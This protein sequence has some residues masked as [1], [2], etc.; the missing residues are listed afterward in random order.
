MSG[1]TF[2]FDYSAIDS[3]CLRLL[4]RMFGPLAER[5]LCFPSLNAIYDRALLDKEEK[6]FP[7]KILDAM[8][9]KMEIGG[10]GSLP[11]GPVVV[12]AN[13]PFG[14]IE[15]LLMLSLLSRM[16]G[17]VKVMAN[18]MLGI[19]PDLREHFFFVN[20]FGGAKAK[21]DNLLSMKNCIRH[22]EGGGVLGVFPA[23][24][25]SS[26]DL[27]KGFVRDIEW[28]ET[29]AK[30]VR[31]AKA[32][33]VPVYF[34]GHNGGFFNAAGL[35]HP[36]LRTLLLPKN[37]VNKEHR[38]FDVEVGGAIAWSEF[39]GKDDGMI[40]KMLRLSSYILKER[41]KGKT[42]VKIDKNVAE[43]I[44][45]IPL[46]DLERDIA[47]LSEEERLLDS[48]EYTVFCARAEQ[49]PNVLREIGRLREETY[50]RAGEGT[51]QEIDLDKYDGYYRHLFIWNNEKR[52]IVGAY[53]L[54]L[55][56]EIF[57]K[58]GVDGF[59]TRT[60]F[61]YDERLL[62]KITP[63]IE[64]GRSFIR[65]EYQ[66]S[67][68]ALLLL[69]KGISAFFYRHKRYRYLFGPV[70]ISN[71]YK[72]ASQAIIVRLLE[73]GY[74]DGKL[75]K[76]VTVNH[77]FVCNKKEEW[78]LPEYDEAVT[79]IE[80]ASSLVGALEEDGKGVPVLVRQYLKMGGRAI[81]FNV[82]PDF[83]NSLDA[84]V[85]LDLTMCDAKTMQRYMGKEKYEEYLAFH[86]G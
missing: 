43:I 23:G 22:L 21:R 36:R 70:S 51:L 24:E 75:A 64:L 84:F 61:N 65:S 26:V 83:C 5:A 42:V 77:P 37:F 16:R 28:S 34:H 56:D 86:R 48:C 79:D 11:P 59:Y 82:D 38:T 81:A 29:I 78:V 14:G 39:D 17:D 6:I 55:S 74:F 85:Y 41:K 71:D 54:G 15:G 47:L 1:K 49:L 35:V 7:D 53:R 8:G 27:R 80:Y 9:V 46:D 31:R 68:G 62:G 45:P 73:N 33:V 67:F 50:R 40:M 3:G 32:S 20:P 44:S 57:S 30:L 2:Q 10:G 76:L 25:V 58:Y 4:A 69:W 52:E 19:M 12:V 72:P 13:H 18:S 63:A 60:C 66:R